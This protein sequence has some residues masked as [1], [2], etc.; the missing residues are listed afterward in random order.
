MVGLLPYASGYHVGVIYG[1]NEHDEPRVIHF[2][3]RGLT[4]E[5]VS[6]RWLRVFSD[7]EEVRRDALSSWCDLIAENRAN[8]E[9]TFGFD[10]DNPWVD[11]EGV[12]R[13]ENDTALSL[14]C[15]TFVMTL[16]RCVRIELL[17]IKTWQHREDDAAEQAALTM[18][19]AG[20]D[21]DRATTESARQQVGYMR[22][23]AE[24]VAGASASGPRPVPFKR[25]EELGR[26]IEMYL[27]R[28][29][30]ESS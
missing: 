20:H 15:A 18:A 21:T 27:I 23:R 8:D 5:P 22:Y 19:L 24:E 10:F 28:S 4:S 29:Q 17:D 26:E 12:I 13:T 16:F 2:T 30:A 1:L 11:D 3:P 6:E 14:T 25:A 7:I 9:I